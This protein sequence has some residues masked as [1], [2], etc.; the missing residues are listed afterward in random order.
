LR[1]LVSTRY[2]RLDNHDLVEAVIP[3]LSDLGFDF[4]E[5]KAGA[6]DRRALNSFAL[7]D[8]RLYLKLTTEKVQAEVQRGQV[9]QYGLVISNSDVGDG[10]VRVEPLILV[11]ACEN[12]LI[13]ETALRQTHLGRNQV[14]DDIEALLSDETKQ[15]S[16][17]AFFATVQDVIR[18]TAKPEVFE[19]AVNKLREAANVPIRNFDLPTIVERSLREI[20]VSTTEVV[21]ASILDNL[22]S[23]AHGSGLNKWGVSNAYTFAAGN[24]EGLSYEDATALERAGNKI[25]DLNARQWD[26][27]NAK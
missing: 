5:S 21:K 26:A 6:H 2:R 25:L 14:G 9:V 24:A 20:G 10:S 12:G 22:A 4:N 8:R 16:D 27:I 7:T 19:R 15:L 13:L 18:N 23:G 3:I 11:L 1:A 17:R